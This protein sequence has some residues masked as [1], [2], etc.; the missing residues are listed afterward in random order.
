V[1]VLRAIH[2]LI[3]GHVATTGDAL[4]VVEGDR[5]YS[6]RDLN[7]AANLFARRLMTSG[8]RRG[9]RADVQMIPSVDLAVVLLAILKT[10]GCYMWRH[11]DA[12]SFQIPTVSGKTAE[13]RFA[14]SGKTAERRFAVDEGSSLLVD[15][16]P[17]NGVCGGPNLPVITRET[18]IA[19]VLDRAAGEDS[20]AVPHATIIAMVS[21]A[22]EERSP[23]AG[24]PGAFDLWAALLSGATAVVARPRAVAA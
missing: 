6:Y 3:E 13:C 23:W 2:R 14:V 12:P 1:T 10:G 9:M 16:I 20:I 24:E 19:C 18:D 4:A 15:D 7:A 17:V 5:A 22:A 21:C 11:G 8:F